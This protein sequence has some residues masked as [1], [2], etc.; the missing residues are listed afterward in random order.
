MIDVESGERGYQLCQ[1]AWGAGSLGMKE[2]Q[3][4]SESNKV[5][6]VE[7]SHVYPPKDASSRV[8]V[9]VGRAGGQ[10]EAPEGVREVSTQRCPGLHCPWAVAAELLA[11]QTLSPGAASR[12]LW[13][14]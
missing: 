8:S 5:S 7:G 3:G 9:H 11:W 14:A 10:A 6:H 1:L 2:N 12:R 13:M 4:V